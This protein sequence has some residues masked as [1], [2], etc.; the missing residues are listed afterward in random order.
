MKKIITILFFVVLTFISLGQDFLN[1]PID[2]Q[3]EMTG[4]FGEYRKGNESVGPHFHVGIDFSTGGLTGIDILSPAPGYIEY[5]YINDPLYGNGLVLYVPSFNNLITGEQGIKIH[6]AH[7][8]SVG[9]SKSTNGRIIQN[10][11]NILLKSSGNEYRRIDLLK[12]KIEFKTGEVLA[13][14]GE[15]GNVPPHLHLEILDINENM[16]INPAFYFDF[17]YNDTEMSITGIEIDG[18]DYTDKSNFLINSDSNFYIN[19]EVKLRYNINPKIISVR[20]NNTSVFQIDF[21]YI[22]SDNLYKPE[23]IYVNSTNSEY[24]YS[25]INNSKLSI[26][27]SNLWES[28]DFNSSYEG[29]IMIEDN[30]GNQ[31]VRSFKMIPGGD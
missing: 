31:Y 25:I 2:R 3:I 1:M 10:I 14:S 4:Y 27:V 23:E 30:W 20:L 19:P 17:K 6:F 8:E 16:F 7:L 5:F 22:L 28:I 18:K 26:I 12:N 15:S 24:W 21:S 13:S 9:S 29:E 11:Y